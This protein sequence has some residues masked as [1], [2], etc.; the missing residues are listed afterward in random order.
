MKPEKS[1]VKDSIRLVHKGPDGEIKKI[2]QD[3]MEV[4]E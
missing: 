2:V 3:N 1:K 4:L